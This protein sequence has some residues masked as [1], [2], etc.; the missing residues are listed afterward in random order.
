MS[1]DHIGAHFYI[2]PRDF[3]WEANGDDAFRDLFEAGYAGIE[4]F[5]DRIGNYWPMPEAYGLDM[6][7]GHCVPAAF[8]EPEQLLDQLGPSGCKHV[9]NSGP[10]EWNSRTAAD[11][12][13]TA[14]FLNAAGRDLAKHGVRIHYH[15]HA[16]EFT[17]FENDPDAGACR[18]PIDLLMDAFDPQYVGL[19]LD[20][21]WLWVAEGDVNPFFG[22][23]GD[24]VTILHLRDF[25]D[26]K[27]TELGNGTCDLKSIIACGHKLPNVVHTFVEQDPGMPDPIGSLTTS[28]EYLRSAFQI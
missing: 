10:L 21:G 13:K 3:D 11:Y 23:Y 5:A 14:E 28:R 12:R 27:P 15:N 26:G 6:F 1:L 20:A 4:D 7:A 17:P 16:F 2:M 19:C 18:R 22:N 25:K 8:R 9:C 24:R